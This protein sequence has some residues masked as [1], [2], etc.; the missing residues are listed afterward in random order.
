MASATWEAVATAAGRVDGL[1]GRLNRSAPEPRALSH[2]LAGVLRELQA[3]LERRTAA[4]RARFEHA[5]ALMT[6]LDPRATLQRGFAIV[7]KAGTRR[8]VSSTRKVKG[9]DR[10]AISVTDGAFWAEVS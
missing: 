5:S 7:Q 4:D 3:G 6:A 10:L 8:V 1:L 9:G 2:N